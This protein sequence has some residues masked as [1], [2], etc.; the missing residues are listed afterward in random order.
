MS[1]VRDG[2]QEGR[3]RA[4]RDEKGEEAVLPVAEIAGMREVV[5]HDK[6]EMS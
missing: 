1:V 4:E 3:N 2:Q 6:F 5:A